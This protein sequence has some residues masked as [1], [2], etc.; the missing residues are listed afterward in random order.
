MTTSDDPKGR[1]IRRQ[2]LLG[3]LII[4]AGAGLGFLV[5]EQYGEAALST[6][7]E[8][9]LPAIALACVGSVF[10]IIA[11]IRMVF[12]RPKAALGKFAAKGALE[13]LKDVVN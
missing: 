11:R 8:P 10:M 9:M 4:L 1:A 12:H 7:A 3:F 5:L 13:I 2:A 6:D